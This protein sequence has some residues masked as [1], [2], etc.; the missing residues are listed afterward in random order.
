MG[1]LS[2][3]FRS[4]ASGNRQT[5]QVLAT[6]GS[7]SVGESVYNSNFHIGSDPQTV[8]QIFEEHH[9]DQQ[10]LTCRREVA[11]RER[12]R[13]QVESYWNMEPIERDLGGYGA[14]R[15]KDAAR[16]IGADD[17]EEASALWAKAQFDLGNV[18]LQLWTKS[19]PPNLAYLEEARLA[20]RE[21]IP[22]WPL[23]QASGEWTSI[24]YALGV[25]SRQGLVEMPK[26]GLILLGM[27]ARFGLG[28]AA[29]ILSTETPE[30][31]LTKAR[32]KELVEEAV[33]AYQD[34]LKVGGTTMHPKFG[35]M[36]QRHL[37]RCQ[38]HLRSLP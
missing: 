1:L 2:W 19:S 29:D 36:V 38:A 37:A 7:I 22:K 35:S 15:W 13:K 12:E 16:T 34:A 20:F 25:R 30:K 17:I 24:A 11:R 14:I 28:M 33:A 26:E 8:R 5:R 31:D 32:R 9:L 27:I 21:G 18:L 3:F 23:E 4:G 6:L 10:L